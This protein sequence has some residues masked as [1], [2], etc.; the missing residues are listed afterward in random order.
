MTTT[1]QKIENEL[2]AILKYA[3]SMNLNDEQ[4]QEIQKI[5]FLYSCGR[6]SP[7]AVAL[8]F[9]YLIH[10]NVDGIYEKDY[11]NF[12]QTCLREYY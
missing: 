9:W 6:M 10:N 7:L 4:R 3:N 12:E 8:R 1:K 5:G 11:Q 2:N